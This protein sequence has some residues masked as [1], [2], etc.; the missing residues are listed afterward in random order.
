MKKCI[1]GVTLVVV[2][3]FLYS[4]MI[5]AGGIHS[6]TLGQ[7]AGRILAEIF[8]AGEHGQIE[9]GF[10]EF[11]ERGAIDKGIVFSQLADAISRHIAKEDFLRVYREIL[12]IVFPD[13]LGKIDKDKAQISIRDGRIILTVGGGSYSLVY[14]QELLV[15]VEED[16]GRGHGNVWQAAR[17]VIVFLLGLAVTA[18]SCKR[19]PGP[20]ERIQVQITLSPVTEKTVESALPGATQKIKSFA[21]GVIAT[22]NKAT[23]LP[24]SHPGSIVT[25]QGK[26][27]LTY[28]IGL[29]L[30]L[31]ATTGQKALGQRMVDYIR[32]QYK[33]DV[34]DLWSSADKSTGIN[35]FI[36]VLR[37]LGR[38]PV[39]GIIN[40]IDATEVNN[41]IL[42]YWVDVGPQAWL[43]I[44]MLHLDPDRNF[45]FALQ[46]GEFILTLQDDD[47]GILAGPMEVDIET[48]IGQSRR[49]RKKHTEHNISTYTFFGLLIESAKKKGRSDVVKRFTKSRKRV[50]GWMV[51]KSYGNDPEGHPY[52]YQGVWYGRSNRIPES[53]YA[54]D[55]NTWPAAF[56][57][58]AISPVRAEAAVKSV[59]RHSLVKIRYHRP[60]G[61][62]VDIIG[63]DFSDPSQQVI[64]RV[65]GGYH[66]MVS[67]E[68]TGGMILAYYRLA[69]HFWQ[70]DEKEKAIKYKAKGDAL[71]S[72]IWD[73]GITEG[74]VFK[75]PYASAQGVEVGHGWKTPIGAKAGLA[76]IFIVFAA[77]GFF[78]SETDGGLIIRKILAQ[79]P[80]TVS[81]EA[82]KMLQG[83]VRRATYEEFNKAPKVLTAEEEAGG[84][85]AFHFTGKAWDALNR[86]AYREAI[87]WADEVI[88]IG[89]W[90][91]I[92][93]RQQQIKKEHGGIYEWNWGKARHADN[94]GWNIIEA[95]NWA[96][97][98]FAVAHWIKSMAYMHLGEK[99]KAKGRI[100]EIFRRY[101]LAQIWDPRGPGFWNPV[102]SLHLG[103]A[104]VLQGL[105]LEVKNELEAE[106]IETGQPT[107]V[108]IPRRGAKPT[109][110]PTEG[111][112]EEPQR[113]IPGV[114]PGRDSERRQAEKAPKPSS[115]TA[116][117]ICRDGTPWGGPGDYAFYYDF[118]PARDF[119][120]TGSLRIHIPRQFAGQD[121]IAQL[122]PSHASYGDSSNI[123]RATIPANGIVDIKLSG[124]GKHKDIK[125]IS[126]HSGKNPWG[127]ELNSGMVIWEK[128]EVIGGSAGLQV[129][130]GI[131]QRYARA[132][133]GRRIFGPQIIDRNPQTPV[134]ARNSRPRTKA[135]VGNELENTS[136]VG[137]RLLN[138]HKTWGKKGNYQSPDE[139]FNYTFEMAGATYTVRHSMNESCF[140]VNITKDG[141]TTEK[142]VFA[143]SVGRE[144]IIITDKLR[145][146]L[147][148]RAMAQLSA[149]EDFEQMSSE[150]RIA[151]LNKVYSGFQTKEDKTDFIALWRKVGIK[152]IFT[153]DVIAGVEQ[154]TSGADLRLGH[155]GGEIMELVIEYKS[156]R[157]AGIVYKRF[158]DVFLSSL[159]ATLLGVRLSEILG[160]DIQ[161]D[162]FAKELVTPGNTRQIVLGMVTDKRGGLDMKII[163]K[164]LDAVKSSGADV[165]ILDIDYTTKAT[166]VLANE[167]GW[168]ERKMG[169]LKDIIGKGLLDLLFSRLR[170]NGYGQNIGKLQDLL[171]AIR[172][173][174]GRIARVDNG[175]IDLSCPYLHAVLAKIAWMAGIQPQV[176]L[177]ALY[178]DLI[179]ETRDA[180]T[181]NSMKNRIVNSAVKNALVDIGMVMKRGLLNY[182]ST[183]SPKLTSDIRELAIA[184]YGKD[185]SSSEELTN[186]IDLAMA[187]DKNRDHFGIVEDIL[188][189]VQFTGELLCR[190]TRE[191]A[192]G[193]MPLLRLLNLGRSISR[194]AYTVPEGFKTQVQLDT[195][196]ISLEHLFNIDSVD[197]TGRKITIIPKALD[198]RETIKNILI[199]GVKVRIIGNPEKLGLIPEDRRHAVIQEAVEKYLGLAASEFTG[200]S[201]DVKTV[202][203]AISELGENARNTRAILT[204]E[205]IA[206]V[207]NNQGAFIY[208]PRAGE[209]LRDVIVVTTAVA[210]DNAGRFLE[211][212]KTIIL[213]YLKKQIPGISGNEAVWREI[214][215]GVNNFSNTVLFF[216]LPETVKFTERLGDL[217]F[218][219]L[220]VL[221]A[222]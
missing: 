60:D 90:Q 143:M 161:L 95:H 5:W 33:R 64:K 115:G 52:F 7:D 148:E 41:G 163:E 177:R 170:N 201:I 146:I 140:A 182:E 22:I 35:G 26:V 167:W 58:E 80:S 139:G 135:W 113:I 131:L 138:L 190:D 73:M 109:R 217:E 179:E 43:G 70:A 116:E 42:E 187:A 3:S 61:K 215:E 92:A 127:M 34:R 178:N 103:Y 212:S 54:T 56:G 114:V 219:R 186:P 94:E 84:A 159:D 173:E 210:L 85:Q 203:D 198:V 154:L 121:V 101:S 44:G 38:K 192:S 120:T 180:I 40:G 125:Q 124:F 71:L 23:E 89:D 111:R 49:F 110:S 88:K 145:K 81:T 6:Q 24:L 158:S 188:A 74:G 96:L 108:S 129:P 87:K 72:F 141:L 31:M 75:V 99:E 10:R 152:L 12:F 189:D 156:G 47:G 2:I 19:T 118:K 86:K 20:E 164:A 104:E 32:A 55:T 17:S 123:V 76:S 77:E 206:G 53:P 153:D 191:N 91:K 27:V 45:E 93:L 82:R 69:A 168:Q 213:D 184:I 102:V 185:V 18:S 172:K 16:K 130:V 66:P 46:I 65:R 112:I 221:I 195:L 204:Q 48:D 132:V 157:E 107:V 28:D 59:E 50:A 68:W 197:P 122:L 37:A 155:I 149:H 200:L 134:I 150:E 216:Q 214:T 63:V 194:I 133:T 29:T 207:E 193:V 30:M 205:D 15:T 106:G 151:L 218:Y 126:I 165:S 14:N 176:L 196:A 181:T 209:L 83:A 39:K 11:M 62:T 128:V 136:E 199:S 13:K 211:Q 51:A 147:P 162:T 78:P 1:K 175:R 4:N 105:W 97:N 67:P 174:L 166:L 142:E 137:S 9:A 183:V 144:G 119:P 21:E 25:D 169:K 79:I 117:V 36:R 57:L 100:K 222:A 208:V 220:I 98:H 202:R 171:L 8:T 160:I